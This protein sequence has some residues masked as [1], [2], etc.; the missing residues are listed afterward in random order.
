MTDLADQQR[1]EKFVN[2]FDEDEYEKYIS[3]EQS[4]WKNQTIERPT[5][6]QRDL[7]LQF[8]TPASEKDEQDIE[9]EQVYDTRDIPMGGKVEIVYDKRD[10]PP[11]RVTRDIVTQ[12]GQPIRI[13]KPQIE[14]QK[15]LERIAPTIKKPALR[16]RITTAIK[17]F[18][19]RFRR[20]KQ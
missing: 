4:K 6:K 18:F 7:A 9:S 19:G 16:Q 17:G 2:G 10:L 3:G 11:K 1:F 12:T 13:Q 8:R 20:K 5:D 15:E 14:T